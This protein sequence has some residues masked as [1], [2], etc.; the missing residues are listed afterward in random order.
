MPTQIDYP[1]L[2]DLAFTP[3]LNQDGEMPQNLDGKIGVYAIFDRD[4]ALQFVYY[5]R[6]IYASLKQH[7]IRQPEQCYWLKTYT[8]S[9][10]SR[11]LLQEIQG[12]WIAENQ[13]TPPGNDR[14]RALWL[15][16]IDAKVRM[17]DRDRQTYAQSDEPGKIKLLKQV[18]RR[19]EAEILEQL[20]QRGVTL[21]IRFNPK[22]KEQ[23]LLDLK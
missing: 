7:L 15:D 23:G 17:S 12:A 22:L 13:I 9:Q 5:S 4:R 2:A 19:Y 11:T 10:P 3:Y 21:E 6:N 16:P 1:T 18:A 14:D 8:V 20:K